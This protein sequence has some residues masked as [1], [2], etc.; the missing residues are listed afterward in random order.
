MWSAF[1]VIGRHHAYAAMLAHR[2]DDLAEALVDDLD[3]VHGRLDHAR[4]H[5]PC[6]HWRS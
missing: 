4:V 5:R 6:R 1:A 3:R 2:R